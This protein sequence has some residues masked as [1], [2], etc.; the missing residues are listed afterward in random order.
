MDKVFSVLEL[1]STVRNLLRESFPQ[2]IWVCGEIQGF[3]PERNKRHIYFELVQKDADSDNILAKVKIALFAGKRP[4]IERRIAETKGAFKLSN[5]IEVKIL[6]EVSLHPPTGQYSLIVHD[7]DTVYTLGKVAQN[8][9]KIIE[10]LKKRGLLNRNKL[11]D[12]ALVP[13]NIGLITAYDSAAYHDFTNELALSGYGFKVWACNCHMQG[14]AVEPDVLKALSFLNKT[15][16]NKLDAIVITRGG[17]ST[18]DLSFF[19]NKKIAENIA[20]SKFPVISALGHQIDSTITDMVSHT[21]CKTPTKAAQLLVERVKGVMD[22]LDNLTE[23]IPNRASQLIIKS[24]QGLANLSVKLESASS[25]FFRIHREELLNRKHR[26]VNSA[27]M[28]VTKEKDAL[29]L[30]LKNLKLFPPKIIKAAIEKIKYL[31]EKIKILDPKNTLKRGYSITLK[32]GKAIKSFDSLN[33][34]DEILS[35]FY[36]GEVLSKISKKEKTDV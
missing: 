25:R 23:Q 17:G 36:E 16:A 7:I 21:I 26:V 28:I 22:E 11:C 14:K 27:K 1:N 3:R 4:L 24:S 19:D 13:L 2:T 29:K 12:L 15:V 20:A 34:N 18:A 33:I 5:D 31:Q 9:L 30:S 35:V 10:D 8:R 32:G 6:C